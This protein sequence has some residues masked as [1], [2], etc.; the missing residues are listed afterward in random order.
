MLSTLPAR[1]AA[2]RR[3]PRLRSHISTTTPISPQPPAPPV[4]VAGTYNG[5][6]SALRARSPS[7]V[8]AIRIGKSGTALNGFTS[9]CPLTTCTPAVATES[10]AWDGVL[11]VV[12]L[13]PGGLT[14]SFILL[15]GI[16]N[17]T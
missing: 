6:P 9:A 15:C 7:R 4:L 17:G 1:T 14:V 5:T 13:N 3:R 10:V 11:D 16:R 2:L 12:T 8:R